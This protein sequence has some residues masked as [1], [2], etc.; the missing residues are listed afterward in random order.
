MGFE[1]SIAGRGYVSRI[2]HYVSRERL[3]PRELVRVSRNS[4]FSRKWLARLETSYVADCFRNTI[5]AIVSFPSTGRSERKYAKKS[6][7][8]FSNFPLRLSHPPCL[9]RRYREV[10]TFCRLSVVDLTIFV[11]LFASNQMI[12]DSVVLSNISSTE[13]ALL[14]CNVIEEQ[15]R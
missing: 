8:N 4:D 3:I 10:L 2:A 7:E 5:A 15:P 13:F 12:F 6:T 1:R 14:R 11:P 9:G